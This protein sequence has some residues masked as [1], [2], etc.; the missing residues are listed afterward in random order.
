MNNTLSVGEII[1]RLI[2][3]F[4]ASQDDQR[5]IYSSIEL[6]YQLGIEEGVTA[7]LE[8]LKIKE[9]RENHESK[10]NS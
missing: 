10:N 3:R 9:R 6:V 1:E 7:I 5:I 2:A 8:H 4:A